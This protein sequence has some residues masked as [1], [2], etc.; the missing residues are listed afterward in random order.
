MTRDEIDNMSDRDLEATLDGY[1]IL[2][3]EGV[4]NRRD[5]ATIRRLAAEAR[6]R[7]GDIAYWDARHDA[8]LDRTRQANLR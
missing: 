3:D 7:A 5:A 6:S 2:Q 4:T 1:Q 8:T